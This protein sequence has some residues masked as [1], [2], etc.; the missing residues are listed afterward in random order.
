MMVTE[1]QEQRVRDAAK[2]L[3]DALSDIYGPREDT[4]FPDEPEAWALSCAMMVELWKG[5]GSS[6]TTRGKAR[7]F[8]YEFNRSKNKQAERGVG[9]TQ[10]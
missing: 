10:R 4:E 9:V 7:Q 2:E 5:A 6:I 3:D 1:D 8:Q